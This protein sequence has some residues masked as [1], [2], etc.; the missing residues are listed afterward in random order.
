M[1]KTI[2]LLMILSSFFFLISCSED[3]INLKDLLNEIS[4]EYETGETAL[5]LKSDILLPLKINKAIIT[6]QSSNNEIITVEGNK[7]L[8][9]RKE[10]DS[11]VTLTAF[12]SYKNNKEYKNFE[13]KVLK[14]TETFEINFYDDSSLAN[15]LKSETVN[16]GSLLSD[17][18][19]PEKTGYQFIG[20]YDSETGLPFDYQLII[21]KKYELYA[22]FIEDTTYIVTVIYNNGSL[23]EKFIV[24][25]GEKLTNLKIPTKAGE[26]FTGYIIRETNLS[27]DI[28]TEIFN[29]LTLVATYIKDN[30]TE[31]TIKEDFNDLESV[32]NNGNNFS[33]YR[34][35]D[36]SGD[37]QN[38]PQWDVINGRIDLGMSPGGH[39]ITVGGFGNHL[40]EAGLGRI[41]SEDFDF[42][43][44]YLEF[45]ARLPFS[46]K[47]TY[48]QR[49]G[50]DK[51]NNVKITIKV[52]GETIRVLQ[53][54]NDD[55]ANKGYKFIVKDIDVNGKFNFSIA[56][57]SG[58]RLTIDNIL[59]VSNKNSIPEVP[60]I[61][62]LIDFED[63]K[64]KY[65]PEEVMVNLGGT[66]YYIKEVHTDSMHLDKEK[67]YMKL[68]HGSV[69]ARFRGLSNAQF[70]TPT[71]YL[72]SV[73]SYDIK[74][75]SFS[76]R[77]FGSEG[78]FHDD[79]KINVYVK[80]IGGEYQLI[81]TVLLTE[82]FENYE[83]EINQASV[84]F[85]IEVV[86][87]TVNIDNIK[88]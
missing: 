86:D 8:V 27:F 24:K 28:N 72:S 75:I 16:K 61:N 51:A 64:F 60:K 9:N 74:T 37:Y 42:G 77:Y 3:K 6:W 54:E 47:S 1:R 11:L 76:A 50:K 78:F 20:F 57:S 81:E 68:E 63:T 31:T 2:G 7:G 79:S 5:T 17:D 30:I 85:K 56:V 26:I 88:Y 66:N 34:D 59:F 82:E 65:S 32:K 29:D 12:I 70:S 44:S 23:D 25:A 33:E 4:I 67:A 55:I 46:P 19:K 73:K 43:L 52:N 38:A 13:F 39:A 80:I 41:M 83:V 71:A 49:N 45:D 69:V 87:G 18:Y 10:E 21:N 35:F 53:F 48:P 40:G 58:H 36:Y 84:Y 62:G 15:L 22:Y 14:K